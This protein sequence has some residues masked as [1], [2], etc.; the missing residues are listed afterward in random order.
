[1]D[2]ATLVGFIV[3]WALMIYPM[4]TGAGLSAFGDAASVQIVLGGSLMVLLMRSQ[5]SDFITMWAQVFAKIFIAKV[6]DPKELIEQ[7]TE[8]ANI[9]R[10]DGMIAL[11]GQDIAN[12]FLAKGVSLL[13]DGTQPEVV[14]ATL[15][16]D[17]DL[18]KARH[19]TAIQM[20]VSW[21]DIAPA[22]GMIGTLIG[23]VGMLQNM[24]DPK[25][26]GPAMAVALLTTMYGA[27]VANVLAKP[28]SEK[29]GALSERE[30]ANNE[31]IMQA[32]DEIQKQTN[33]RIIS[34][35]LASRLPPK[36]R[37]ELADA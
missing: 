6:D 23:L 25:A 4:A 2:I 14:T 5:L 10:K 33:P 30:Q 3:A 35:I 16:N 32:L 18:M 20:W 26:I 21:A 29:L 8:L 15:E 7:I 28:V 37:A 13:V 34:G 17:N 11:E 31:L 9:V 36:V 22:M 12:P 1:M 27:I 19:D 24:S